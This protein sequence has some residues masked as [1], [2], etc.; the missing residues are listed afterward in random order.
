[1]TLPRMRTAAGAIE[2]IRKLDPNTN[3]TE[4]AIRRAIKR[5]EVRMVPAGRK[6]LINLDELI[7]YF[8]T[9]DARQETKV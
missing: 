2:E 7:E 6:Q 4:C 9:K 1:M 3:I 5:G 8:A